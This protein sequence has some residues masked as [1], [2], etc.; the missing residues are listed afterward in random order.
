MGGGIVGHASWRIA[1]WINIPLCVIPI[2]GLAWSLTLQVDKSSFSS[3]IARIDFI[4]LV[5]FSGASTSFLIGLTAGGTIHLWSS[6]R[7]IL[8]LVFG[9]LLYV[10]FVVVEWK[11]ASDPMMPLRIFKDR[12]ANT[13]F[14][15]AYLHGLIVW[16]YIYY[17]PIFFLGARSQTPIRRYV[18]FLV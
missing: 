12:T 14:F 15:G 16:C 2:L 4:G 18:E 17:L 11:V 6:F 8:P 13:G 9:I 3:K 10:A 1:F 7:T 5:L